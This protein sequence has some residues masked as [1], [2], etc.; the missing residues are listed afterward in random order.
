MAVKILIK[1]MMPESKTNELMPLFRRLRNLATN[2]PGYISGE[3]LKRVDKPGEF[4]IISTW[5]SIDD[6]REY[7]VS[8]ERT[9]IQHEI[10]ARIGT[11]TTYEI[12]QYG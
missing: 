10:D 3:T 11:E 2:Q 12:Y 7:V 9:D 6:W 8:Q 1:R 4:L 5:Q